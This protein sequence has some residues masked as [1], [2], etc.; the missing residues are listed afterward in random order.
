MLIAAPQS[1]AQ[2]VPSDSGYIPFVGNRTIV[3]TDAS[4]NNRNISSLLYYPATSEGANAPV[5]QGAS[6]PAVSFGHGFTLNPNLYVALYRHLASWGY[7]VI[8]PSTET[9]FFPS[10]TNFALDLVFIIKDLKRRNSVSG[11]IF[12]GVVDTSVSGVFGHSMGGGCSVLAGSFDSSITAVASLA[13]ANTNPSSISA[14]NGI[15]SPQLYLSGQRDSIASYWTQQLPHYNNSFPFKQTVNIKGGNHS[16]F[17]LLPGL[18]DLVDNPATITR[19]EQQRLTRRYVTAFFNL[20]L[21]NDSNGRRFLYGSEAA[22]DTTV[23]TAYRNFSVRTLLQGFY[24]AGTQQMIRDTVTVV[25]RSTAPPYQFLSVSKNYAD[26]SGYGEY[27][28][29]MLLPRGSYFFQIIHRNS[30]ETWSAGNA[31]PIGL[32][33]PGYDFTQ[34]VSS[35]FGNNLTLS[36][37][38]YCIFGGDVN[39]DGIVD[40]QDQS[41]ADNDAFNIVTGYTASDVNGD[42]ITDA[43]DLSLIENNAFSFVQKI[44]P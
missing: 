38:K 2:P 30:I 3:F 43:A 44:T 37:T 18:D 39:T 7:I 10:H 12:F 9:G 6:Y 11:D 35:A 8:A 41:I 40:A 36:G 21:K 29:E 27:S 32:K 16:Y 25:A 13:A 22:N 34:S 33:R 23:I 15:R 42:G 1:E 14:A 24:D 20:F 31:P 5:L 4:R 19:A 28:L 17:H 26:A